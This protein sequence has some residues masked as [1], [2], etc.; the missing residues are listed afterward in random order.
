MFFIG[1][2]IGAALGGWNAVKRKGNKLD[3]LQYIAGYGIAFGL[4]FM[5]AGVFYARAFG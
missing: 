5:F 2:I 3:V 4:V 1:F